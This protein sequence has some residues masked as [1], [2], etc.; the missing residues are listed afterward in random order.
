MLALVILE[1]FRETKTRIFET[2][3][4]TV[5]AAARDAIEAE[6]RKNSKSRIVDRSGGPCVSRELAARSVVGVS[7]ENPD[8]CR[9]DRSIVGD[10]VAND[11]VSERGHDLVTGSV[12]PLRKVGRAVQALFLCGV[13]HEDHRCLEPPRKALR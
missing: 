2:H 1:S 9:I 10:D 4:R 7:A 6:H 12:E 13:G 3:E 5:V 11:V 8:A